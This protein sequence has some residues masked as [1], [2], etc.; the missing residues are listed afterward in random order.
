[1]R[2][3]SGPVARG[4]TRLIIPAVLFAVLGACFWQWVNST[5]GAI[6]G[7]I[8]L[9]W[10]ALEL[11]LGPTARSRIRTTGVTVDLPLV[12]RTRRARKVLARI[13][14]AVRASRDVTMQPALHR[15]VPSG[16]ASVQP[17]SRAPPLPSIVAHAD[18]WLLKIQL[19]AS[20]TLGD[21]FAP[22]SLLVS[23]AA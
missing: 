12:Q 10:V 23:S 20:K 15:S 18:E 6:F 7:S 1:M 22:C 13:D 19:P 8:G 9:A 4:G 17:T 14:A 21:E 11:A 16:G 5:S 2:S 3:L